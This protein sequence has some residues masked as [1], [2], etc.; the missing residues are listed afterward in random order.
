MLMLPAMTVQE[1]SMKFMDALFTS[2]SACCVT[3]LIVVDTATFFTL[4]GQIVI[5]MLVQIGALGI[6]SLRPFLLIL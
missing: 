2:V 1:G 5:M 6:I 3:G 4:K